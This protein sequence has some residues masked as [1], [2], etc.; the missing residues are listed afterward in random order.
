MGEP[1]PLGLMETTFTWT[2]V[3]PVLTKGKESLRKGLAEGQQGQ[4]D[5]MQHRMMQWT[6]PSTTPAVFLPA[7]HQGKLSHT[8][9]ER[10]F[11]L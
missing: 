3:F 2:R 5:S 10:H 1:G 4:N 6:E 11:T 9:M 8:M 7:S